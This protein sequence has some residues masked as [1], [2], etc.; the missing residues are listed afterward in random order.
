MTIDRMQTPQHSSPMIFRPA[1]LGDA[2]ALA[3]VHAGRAERDAVDPL[4]TLEQLP[5]AAQL[6]ERLAKA[7]AQGE[8]DRWLT[9][10][11]GGR[12]VGYSQLEDWRENDGT[13]VYLILG[14]VLPEWRGRGIGSEMLRRMEARGRAW[15]A[16]QHPGERAEFAANASS[17]E[18]EAAALLLENGYWVAYTVL[19]MG[20]DP[21]AEIAASPLAEGLQIRPAEA[22]HLRRIATCV[23]ACYQDEFDGG[24]FSDE[25]NAD[26]YAGRLAG[27]GQDPSLWQVAWAGEEVVGQVLSIIERGRAEVFEVSVLPAWRRRGV[28]RALL[29][30]GLLALRQRGVEA[31]RLHTVAEFKTRARDLYQSLGFGVLKEFPRYRK[32]M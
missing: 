27:P 6:A 18:S 23:G 24:R 19:E 29:T 20:L 2:A 10:Q 22:A 25:Y 31:I 14:W 9:A 1:A 5:S 30:R 16:A 13:W 4:S 21:E 17:T 32:E 12:V 3:A 26:W 8:L 28:A 11:A 15:A 7:E